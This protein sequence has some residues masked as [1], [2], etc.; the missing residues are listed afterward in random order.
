MFQVIMRTI[1]FM[2]FV[3]ATTASATR[4]G[5]S[6]GGFLA[7]IEDDEE[8]L[9]GPSHDEE[10]EAVLATEPE[11]VSGIDQY[12]VNRAVDCI[13]DGMVDRE[14][15]ER[16]SEMDDATPDRLARILA[17]AKRIAR[18]D[19]IDHNFV[20]KLLNGAVHLLQRGD[21]SEEAIKKDIEDVIHD[22]ALV[23]GILERAKEQ[24]QYLES[25]RRNGVAASWDA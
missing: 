7:R 25:L 22:P 6:G 9:Y 4:G 17:L 8:D 19:D 21:V 3:F 16:I 14:V 15:I 13:E 24:V 10:W 23:L 5:G 2:G 11:G 12:W 18:V 1:L 20:P